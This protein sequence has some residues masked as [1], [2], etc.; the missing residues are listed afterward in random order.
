RSRR[1]PER[2]RRVAVEQEQRQAIK[3]REVDQ[4]DTNVARGGNQKRDRIGSG[5]AE[6]EWNGLQRTGNRHDERQAWPRE[7]EREVR[8]GFDRMSVRERLKE[9]DR[10]EV[11]LL[12]GK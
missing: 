7:A 12:V 4:R 10:L 8:R 9:K 3:Q 5:D 2:D 6:R 11:P 1:G